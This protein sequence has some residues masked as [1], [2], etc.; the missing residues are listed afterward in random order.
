VGRALRRAPQVDRV[1]SA[2]LRVATVMLK[3][4]GDAVVLE[5]FRVWQFF[6]GTYRRREW[7]IAARECISRRDI[8]YDQHLFLTPVACFPYTFRRPRGDLER[9]LAFLL[10][11][12]LGQCPVVFLT[13]GDLRG[14]SGLIPGDPALVMAGQ[15]ADPPG[16]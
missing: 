6:D 2:A 8:T 14:P 5:A 13:R 12:L 1:V 3:S 10:R 16:G 4:T 9:V 7:S 15:N 11:R